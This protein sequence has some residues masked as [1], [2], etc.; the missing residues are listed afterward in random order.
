MLCVI[1]WFMFSVLDAFTKHFTETYSV[2]HLL[3][4]SSTMGTAL[5]AGW[6]FYRYGWAGFKTKNWKLFILRGVIIIFGAFSTLKALS[7]ITLADFYGIV[8]M[9][10]FLVTIMSVLIL[11]EKIGIHRIAALIVGFIGVLILAGPQMNSSP[12][13]LFWVFIA[14][15]L[16]SSSTILIRKIGREKVTAI[17][18]FVPAFSTMVI[19]V[20]LALVMHEKLH[21]PAPAWE[22]AY[23]FLLGTLGFFGFMAY[24]F[25]LT[26]ATVLA[27]FQ[28]IG[29]NFGQTIEFC[30][31][32]RL[33]QCVCFHQ[34]DSNKAIKRSLQGSNEWP[35]PNMTASATPAPRLP[36]TMV[37]VAACS[38]AMRWKCWPWPNNWPH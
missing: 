34:P 20:P 6:I 37:P 15:F 29:G 25:G 16:G 7:M 1:G 13:G 24:S 4:M 26:R 27:A 5:S 2:I 35:F 19:Y 38:G 14:T 10:P 31:R 8:F 3:A 18:A 23:P 11:K 30:H 17:F 33:R 36:N 32:W 12:E 9:S 28:H 22:L 21:I